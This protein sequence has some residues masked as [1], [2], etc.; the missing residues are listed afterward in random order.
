MNQDFQYIIEGYLYPREAKMK[1]L[2]IILATAIVLLGA[3]Y[4]GLESYI[5]GQ[6]KIEADK[7]LAQAP[8][9]LQISYSG[10]KYSLIGQKL[11]F[12]EIKWRHLGPDQK[13]VARIQMQKVEISGFDHQLLGEVLTDSLKGD[14]GSFRPVFARFAAAQ[15]ECEAASEKVSYK[16]SDLAVTDYAVNPL[17]LRAGVLSPMSWLAD[18]FTRTKNI[19]A[20]VMF[21]KISL[22]GLEIVSGRENVTIR[23]GQMAMGPFDG[24][25]LAQLSLDKVSV[26]EQGK[27]R[28]ALD[29][30]ALE[31][32]DLAGWKGVPQAMA[33]D[34]QGLADLLN[35]F[36]LRGFSLAGLSVAPPEEKLTFRL[37]ELRISSPGPMQIGEFTL[38]DVAVDAKTEGG[39][40]LAKFQL[41]GVDARNLI[42][43]LTALKQGK[44]WPAAKPPVKLAGLRLQDA[45]V[46]MPQG[47][48][49]LQSV[50]MT[51]KSQ[52]G[53]EVATSSQAEMSGLKIPA[54]LL[55]SRGVGQVLGDLGYQD[56]V[57]GMKFQ[58]DYDPAK[59]TA[60]ISDLSLS[61]QE[62][63]TL[64]F[65]VAVSGLNLDQL[66]GINSSQEELLRF[67][68]HFAYV[69]LEISYTDASL[70]QRLYSFAAKKDKTTPEQLKA[71]IKENIAQAASPQG[72]SGIDRETQAALL[73]FVDNPQRLTI[74]MKPAS[75]ITLE[76]GMQTVMT[77]GPDALVKMLN[78]QVRAN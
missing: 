56:L 25:V 65:A 48:I 26:E 19:L 32:Y 74:S 67:L 49:S 77:Q 72:R 20:G 4:L 62:A 23:M 13:E 75:P 40:T 61:A 27:T 46:R 14:A 54:A 38:Q 78:V 1:R 60:N 31:G 50:S 52:E 47:A 69:S 42:T 10:L 33:G 7:W 9:D 36:Q 8:K 68:Q 3:G 43:A 22:A 18:D 15:V 63:G 21:G 28:L 44:R 41:E 58:A 59:G 5:S 30:L 24:A 34:P 35:T 70:C 11:S 17:L 57:L 12:A 37:G 16:A 39:L 45:A 66:P 76:A 6:V 64:K 51:S 53:V 71:K 29:K 2:Y 55:D 73:A